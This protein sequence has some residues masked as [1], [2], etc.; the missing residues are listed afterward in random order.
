MRKG[1]QNPT[2]S[3]KRQHDSGPGTPRNFT[4]PAARS[5]P[6]I[7]A[8]RNEPIPGLSKRASTFPHHS[9]PS[10]LGLA[11]PGFDTWSQSGASSLG[12]QT[13][14]SHEFQ[15]SGAMPYPSQGPLS[16]YSQGAQ[17]PPSNYTNSAI[18]NMSTMMFPPA[19]DP[20]GYPSQPLTT[21]ENNQQYSKN[22]PYVN[23]GFNGMENTS[24][25]LPPPSRGSRDD[26]LEAQFFAL[27]PYIEQQRQAQR[28]SVNFA[29]NTNYGN[30]QTLGT[31]TTTQMPNGWPGSQQPMQQGGSMTNINIQDLFGG[32]EWMGYQ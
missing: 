13:P 32:N 1:H 10:A 4:P 15:P 20:L 5:H 9:T 22:S 12:P 24:P 18:T 14:N 21:F 28:P 29:N 3:R 17:L 27:P 7:S 23:Q 2:G 31:P 19:D 16:A 26:N 6:D 8:G 30:N 11:T 25:M